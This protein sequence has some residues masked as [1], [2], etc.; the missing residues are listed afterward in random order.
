MIQWLWWGGYNCSFFTKTTP[1]FQVKEGHKKDP[2]VPLSDSSAAPWGKKSIVAGSHSAPKPV[3]GDTGVS[4]NLHYAW[5]V[6]SLKQ[7]ENAQDFTFYC[8]KASACTVSTRVLTNEE[9]SYLAWLFLWVQQTEEWA[10]GRWGRQRRAH[11]NGKH[12]LQWEKRKRTY[13]LASLG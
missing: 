6:S 13:R 11:C 3:W 5:Q 7:G 12:R 8:T 1:V 4:G 2:P 10:G 9:T